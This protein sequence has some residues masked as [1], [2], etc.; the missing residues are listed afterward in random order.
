[1]PTRLR[2]SA[3]GLSER[4]ALDVCTDSRDVPP[5]VNRSAQALG[6]HWHSRFAVGCSDYSDEP[7]LE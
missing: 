4:V 7:E 1:M 3:A 6:L 5:R 2:W